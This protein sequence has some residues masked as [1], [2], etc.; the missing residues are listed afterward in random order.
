MENVV[1]TIYAAH[2]QTC[3]F[4][5]LAYTPLQYTT[6]NERLGIQSGVAI[7]SGQY[8]LV[9]YYAIGDGGHTHTVSGDGASVLV[10][11]QHQP[12][13]AGLF[14]QMPF[15]LR[16]TTDDLAPVDRQRYALRKEVT[17]NNV[18][19][20][21]YYLRRIDLSTAAVSL[22]R[23]TGSGANVT[24][25][26]FTPTAANLTPTPQIL[27]NSN[28]NVVTADALVASVPLSVTMN[29]VDIAEYLN[30]AQIIYGDPNRAIISE[31]ALVSGLDKV[32]TIN[33]ASG[34]FNF[35]EVI[36]AQIAS[37]IADYQAVAF[38]NAG[39]TKS[40]DSGANTPL[41]TLV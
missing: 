30:V 3:Q 33:A 31:T 5:R 38:N 14:N 1:P 2:L 36:C 9:G 39:I 32:V 17:I 41:F 23:R 19:Y 15:V 4:H 29:A 22:Q 34:A 12:S 28:V 40:L 10:L 27:S 20:I 13:D 16:R 11:R 7:P 6:L 37:H 26:N 8:P 25:T 24:M 18:V 35:N 21:A